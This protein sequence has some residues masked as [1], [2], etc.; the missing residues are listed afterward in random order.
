MF[1][2]QLLKY[3]LSLFLITSSLSAETLK[4][5]LSTYQADKVPKNF[6]E[7]WQ[8]FDPR[9]EALDVEVLHETEQD[10]VII[11]VIRFRVGIFKGQKSMMAA[12]YGYPKGAKNLPGLVQIHGGGQYAQYQA[13]LTNA[14]RGYATISVAWAGRLNAPGYLVGPDQ[15]K[16]FWKGD[17]S[18]PQ[19]KITTDWGALDAYHAPSRSGIHAFGDLPVSKWSIDSVKSARNSSWFPITMGTRR[20]LTFLEQQPEVNPDK[21]GVYG[22]SMGGKLTVLTAAADKRVKAAAPSCGGIS[23]RAKKHAEHYNGVGDARNLENIT[24]PIVFLSPANDFHGAIDDLPQSIKEIKTDKWRIVAAPHNNHQDIPKAEVATQLWMDQY[25]KNSFTWPKAPRTQILLKNNHK[26]PIV[27]VD[28]DDSMPIESVEVYYTQQGLSGS[29]RNRKINQ[30]W[31]FSKP[32]IHKG[33]YAAV[34]DLY[35]TDKPLWVYANVIYKMD[36]EVTGAGYYYGT[37][38]ANSFINSSLIDLIDAKELKAEELQTSIKKTLLFEDFK[39]DWEKEWFTYKTQKWGRKTHKLY[40]PAYQPPTADATMKLTV[41]AEQDNA[42]II[43]VDQYVKEVQIK[44]GQN[45]EVIFRPSDFKD[46]NDEVMTT[47]DGSK[48]FRLVAA[49]ALRPKTGKVRIIGKTWQGAKPQF[50][51]LIW[52]K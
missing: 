25:L 36:K 31:H 39:S 51:E 5:T 33:K 21:L 28:V 9:K 45:N 23:D 43:G 17:Q 50:K 20:A 40:H 6:E 4:D 29:D 19:Y 52:L 13:I 22:H 42:L 34:L 2:Q 44:G 41:F 15:V 47:W 7:M 30:F 11:K 37:Y 46:A 10:D 8:G 16:A 18:D 49:E 24:C 3:S 27:V 14:K 1:K 35:S 48:E 12:V 26:K 38:K 32:K